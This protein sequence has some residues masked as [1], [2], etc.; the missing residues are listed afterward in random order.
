MK[1]QFFLGDKADVLPNLID[2]FILA[3][4]QL[5]HYL[6]YL[7]QLELVIQGHL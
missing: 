6:L 5:L 1:E 4:F 7:V 3:V 2:S